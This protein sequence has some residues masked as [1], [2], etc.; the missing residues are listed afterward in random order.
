MT[1]NEEPQRWGIKEKLKQGKHDKNRYNS[2]HSLKAHDMKT[3]SPGVVLST[4]G[5]TTGL[6]LK[7]SVRD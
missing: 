5:R 6:G 7:H 3:W 2:I 4:E 1:W